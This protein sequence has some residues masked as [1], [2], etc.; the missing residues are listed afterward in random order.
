[1]ATKRLQMVFLNAEGGRRTI[2]VDSPRADLLPA[3]V[4]QAMNDIILNNAF[5]SNGGDLVEIAG[6]TIVTQ[7]EII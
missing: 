1:M 3:E 2:S 7:E 5:T 6:A 4:S